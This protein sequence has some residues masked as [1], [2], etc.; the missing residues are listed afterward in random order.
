MDNVC[1]DDDVDDDDLLANNLNVKSSL[2]GLIGYNGMFFV[3]L[4]IRSTCL[5]WKARIQIYNGFGNFKI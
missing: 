2:V 1:A 4:Q 5:L 3:L